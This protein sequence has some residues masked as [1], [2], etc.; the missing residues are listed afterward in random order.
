MEFLNTPTIECSLTDFAVFSVSVF[1]ML[2]LLIAIEVFNMYNI[3]D[4]Q[5]VDYAYSASAF[6]FY[7]SFLS[8][9]VA[10]FCALLLAFYL[11]G[12]YSRSPF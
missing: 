3:K 8:C 12:Y 4:K 2:L 5:S 6:R 10:A 11:S 7:S 1:M 9:A